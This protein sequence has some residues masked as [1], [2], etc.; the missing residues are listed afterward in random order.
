MSQ[1]GPRRPGSAP[2]RKNRAPWTAPG[3][4]ENPTVMR[5][6]GQ[7]KSDPDVTKFQP[8]LL[9]TREM[10]PRSIRRFLNLVSVEVLQDRLANREE[11]GRTPSWPGV[12]NS[13]KGRI[14]W[15]RPTCQSQFSLATL[16]RTIHTDI[17]SYRFVSERS[18]KG[19]RCGRARLLRNHAFIRVT[20]APRDG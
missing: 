14:H 8:R 13:I 9:A 5:E 4:S 12:S 6:R 11:G 20:V 1:K 3:R 16:R 2:P 18:P 19:F 15:R 7:P 17:Y 10:A